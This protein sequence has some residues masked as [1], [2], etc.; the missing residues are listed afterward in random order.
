MK[1]SL[2]LI[3]ILI[4]LA[5]LS[6]CSKPGETGVKDEQEKEGTVENTE[7]AS[8]EVA[9]L[10]PEEGAELVL[11]ANGEDSEGEWIQY[12]AEKFTEEYGFPVTLEAVA[13][14]DAPGKLQTDGPAGLGG[15]VFMAPHDHVGNMN[16]AGLI[17][18]NYFTDEYKDRFMESAMQG[19]SIV[20]DGELKTYGFPLAIETCC[21]LLQQRFT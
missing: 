21:T 1:S 10:V 11:W 19:V 5:A 17:Y 9:E 8:N 3:L 2:R 16:T 6:A 18:E 7:D 20:S 4:L 15:D 13:H 12:V 14:V